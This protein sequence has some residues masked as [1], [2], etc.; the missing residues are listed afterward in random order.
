MGYVSSAMSWVFLP[1]ACAVVLHERKF[2]C[3]TTGRKLCSTLTERSCTSCERGIQGFVHHAACL[4][5]CPIWRLFV[6]L[7]HTFQIDGT[8]LQVGYPAS[9]A[10]LC[11]RNRNSGELYGSCQ[12]PVAHAALSLTTPAPRSM[13]VAQCAPSVRFCPTYMPS[14]ISRDH[15]HDHA[16]SAS[17]F[18]CFLHPASSAGTTV[19]REWLEI[20]LK[21]YEYGTK[22]NE[23][24]PLVAEK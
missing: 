19:A 16:C 7:C 8:L 17:H 23:D 3:F 20:G 5:G 10:A 1:F 2:F 13:Q 18:A 9:D 12:Y 24:D 11:F 6:L 22:W 14:C 15:W 4:H 21:W